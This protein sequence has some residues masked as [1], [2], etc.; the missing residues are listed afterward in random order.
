MATFELLL[1]E[2]LEMFPPEEDHSDWQVVRYAS[3]PA[4]VME[5]ELLPKGISPIEFASKVA[6]WRGLTAENILLKARAEWGVEEADVP[7]LHTAVK[8][9]MGTRTSV[10]FNLLEAIQPL[11]PT[12]SAPDICRRMVE[13][14]VLLAAGQ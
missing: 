3:Q 6:G 1:E 2:D 7:R 9:V 13:E 11:L 8:L 12:L 4:D 10:A 14:I 5:E